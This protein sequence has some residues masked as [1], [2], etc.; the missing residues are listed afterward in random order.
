MHSSEI[1]NN[2]RQQ[3]VAE[4]FNKYKEA[5]DVRSGT[6]D[7][8]IAIV[9]T[10]SRH[11]VP[12]EFAE[13]LS[14]VLKKY[15]PDSSIVQGMK[16]GSTKAAYLTTYGLGEYHEEETIEKMKASDAFSIQIDESEVNKVSQLN[17]V[18]EIETKENGLEKRFFK[19]IDLESADAAT[20]TSTVI[21]AFEEENID[22]KAKLIDV[23]MDGC[24]TMIGAKSGVITRMK[25]EVPELRS[26][27]SC[28]SHNI[29][30][31][32]KHGTGS[33]NSD[34]QLALV[35]IYQDIGGARG[36]G[37]KKKKEYEKVAIEM[38][39]EPKPKKRYV[40][41]RFRTLL[42]C[43]P[44][45]INEFIALV[46]YYKSLKKPT[47][48]QKQ[49]QAFFVERADKTRIELKFLLAVT[50]EFCVAIDFFEEHQAHVHNTQDKLEQVLVSQLRKVV[51]ESELNNL[52][53]DSDEI[54]RKSKRE[55]V[56][57]DLDNAK[58]LSKKKIFIGAET[59]KEL[60]ALGLTPD[61]DQI[62][63]F[64]KQVTNFHITT[65]KF[66]Q[67]YFKTALKDLAM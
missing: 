26:T 7:L 33:F 22:V 20:I 28:N 25:E 58:L 62:G 5:E 15:I 41:T 35:D 2:N 42:H 67:K 12:P 8:E 43:I 66:L 59:E 6:R 31:A 30:N 4:L 27:G 47:D 50:K 60:K 29:A 52:A 17:I 63:W 49:L 23:G 44:P 39:I 45:V 53:E 61:S 48:R 11:D 13:C 34:I 54:T 51:D 38:G 9:Q 16:L 3:S 57:L 24:A 64:Y 36:K 46:A 65:G 21:E 56:E 37:L 10:L 18:A 14:A 1:G 40:S 32:M 55:L 19:T